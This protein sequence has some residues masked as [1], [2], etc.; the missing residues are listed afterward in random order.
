MDMIIIS[1]LMSNPNA[2]SQEISRSKNLP[3]STVQRRRNLLERTILR[4]KYTID[5]R[6]FGLLTADIFVKVDKGSEMILKNYFRIRL[7]SRHP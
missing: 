1:A 2:T 7:R 3:L 6:E 4:K 5:V